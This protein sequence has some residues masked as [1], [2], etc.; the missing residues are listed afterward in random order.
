[1]QA[2]AQVCTWWRH[3]HPLRHTPLQFA[4]AAGMNVC[5]L[6]M[7]HGNHE[8][9]RA[10]MDLV[11]DYNATGRGAIATMLDTKVGRLRRPD[12]TKL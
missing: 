5:R 8:S 11:R 4:N 10:V 6:N 12:L 2:T 9:H 1:M 3:C 7:S